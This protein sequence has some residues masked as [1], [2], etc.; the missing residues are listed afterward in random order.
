M[1]YSDSQKYLIWLAS[2]GLTPRKTQALLAVFTTPQEIFESVE[3][4]GQLLPGLGAQSLSLLRAARTQQHMDRLFNGMERTGMLAVTRDDA[5]YPAQ[6]AN[7]PDA[8]LALFVRGRAA[9]TDPRP[10]AIVGSRNCS[11][12]G[13]RMARRIARDLTYAGACVVSGLARGV[14]AAAHRGAIDAQGRTMAVLGSGVDVIYP[15]EH[16]VLVDEILSKGGS[17]VSEY[18]PG[19]SPLP[20]HFPARNRIISG[21]SGGVLLI[22]GAARS[23]AMSTVAH[24]AEQGRDVFALPGQADSP[25][26]A[27]THTLIRDGARL[28]TSAGDL[29]HDLGWQTPPGPKTR[30]QEVAAAILPPEQEKVMQ[31]LQAGPMD[32]D[33]L[34]QTLALTPPALNSLLTILELQGLIRKLPGRKVMIDQGP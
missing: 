34:L 18:P 19:V 15:P 29:L 4:C 21:L 25:L 11:A 7:I 32:T 28:V 26:S 16:L 9:L 27:A 23:G 13:T 22:E 30:A 10:F 8:P 1:A 24:A 31:A 14:D 5:E 17:V 33:A 3:Y 6:L 12:Y 20:H 2:V